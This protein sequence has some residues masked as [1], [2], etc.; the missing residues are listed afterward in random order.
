MQ[1][2]R[3]QTEAHPAQSLADIQEELD[4]MKTTMNTKQRL[5]MI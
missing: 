1:S 4:T 2:Q 3:M 5:R